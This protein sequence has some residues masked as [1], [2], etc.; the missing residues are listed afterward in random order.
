MRALVLV[1]SIAAIAAGCSSSAGAP[2]PETTADS[3]VDANGTPSDA[4]KRDAGRSGGRDAAGRVGADSGPDTEDAG[5]PC[6]VDGDPGQCMT[7]PECAALGDHISTP[8]YCPG[9][10]DIECCTLTP[11]VADNPPT[12]AGYMLMSQSDVTSAMTAWA[13]SIL[14][15]PS[16]YPLFSTATK[17]FG[18]QK[19]LALVEWH[20]PD[21]NNSAV[22]RGVT[23]FE[24][25]G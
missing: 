10:A 25:I 20:P 15:D 4:G 7:V 9:P 22:H 5:M 16:M 3:G 23:L 24:P 2:A 12:P 11:N 13:V 14:N 18:T 21:F 8:D 17:T 6:S 1:T 19:V